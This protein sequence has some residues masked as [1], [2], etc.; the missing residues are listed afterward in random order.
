[1]LASQVLL[2]LGGIE[3][4][5][6]TVLKK[7]ICKHPIMGVSVVDE[8]YNQNAWFTRLKDIDLREL[9]KFK[10][11]NGDQQFVLIEHQKPF[12]RLSE[13]PL[14]VIVIAM[15]E[16]QEQSTGC[17]VFDVGFFFHHNMGDGLSGAAFHLD[18]LDALNATGAQEAHIKI[19]V[20]SI[21]EIPSLP[22]LPPIEA[23]QWP[24]TPWFILKTLFNAFVLTSKDPKKWIGPPITFSPVHLPRSCLLTIFLDSEIA[25]KIV[26]LCRKNNT[27]FTPL[28]TLLI[29]R[30]LSLAYPSHSRFAASVAISLRRFTGLASREMGDHVS[31]VTVHCSTESESG[32]VPCRPIDWNTVRSCKAVIDDATKSPKNQIT[33][34]LRFAS[35]YAAFLKSKERE[36]S[37]EVSNVGLVD[38]NMNGPG[39]AKFRSLLFSQSANVTEAPCSFSIASVKGGNMAISLTWQEG[40]VQEDKGKD[41]MDGLRVELNQLAMEWDLEKLDLV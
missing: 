1:M 36:V 13:L 29:A 27:T 15:H 9:V 4:V 19:P 5:T 14:W 10:T 26:D 37:F 30:Q 7:I 2:D 39:I 6:F 12:E 28:L 25:S 3:A 33:S 20:E 40:I 23:T 34:M 11:T 18:F 31:G 8:E 24:L 21:T 32:Y 35:D 38:G 17:T 22:L 41:I 16:N